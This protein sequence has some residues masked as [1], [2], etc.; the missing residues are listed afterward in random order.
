MKCIKRVL[1]GDVIALV[2]STY[3]ESKD[4]ACDL[5]LIELKTDRIFLLWWEPM[6]KTVLPYFYEAYHSAQ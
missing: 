4:K 3:S 1:V 5:L 6:P 2:H